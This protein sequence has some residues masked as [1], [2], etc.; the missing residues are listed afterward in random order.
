MRGLYDTVN[1]KLEKVADY[2]ELDKNSLYS[3]FVTS[4]YS[5][6]DTDKTNL[7]G[8]EYSQVDALKEFKKQR[9]DT[10]NIE[11]RTINDTLVHNRKYLVYT[12]LCILM[13]LS[14][15]ILVIFKMA[16]DLISDKIVIT[17]FMGVLMMLFFI[18]YYFKV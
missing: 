4:P 7:G 9:D 5:T 11:G 2:L 16:P 3:N 14:V 12:I 17:Y 13:I 10:L 15:V 6:S 1:G 18:H 8:N